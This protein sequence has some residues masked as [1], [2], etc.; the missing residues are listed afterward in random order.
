MGMWGRDSE[1]SEVLTRARNGRLVTVTGPGG[2]GKTALADAAAASLAPAFPMG[3]VKVDLTRVDHAAGV[4]EAIAA[5]LGYADYASLI[6]SPGDRPALVLVD[7]CEHVLEAAAAAVGQLLEACQMPT[8]LATSRSPLDLPGESIVALGP[9]PVPAAGVPDLRAPALRLLLERVHDQGVT[10]RDADLPVLVEVCRRLD[11]VPLALELAAARLRTVA[12]ADLLREL[13]EGLHRLSRRRFRGRASH[14]GV[15]EL[16]AWS[17]D[18]LSPAA[19]RFFVRLGIFAGPFPAAM[20]CAVAGDGDEAGGRELL[21]DL[22]TASLIVVD[23]RADATWYRLLHPVRAVALALL[24]EVGELPATRSRF[25]NRVVGAAVEVVTD[26]TDSWESGTLGQLLELY[27]NLAASLR[28]T[29]EHDDEPDRSLV[30]LSVLWG[31]VHQAH[32]SEVRALGEQ[33]LARWDDPALPWWPDAAPTVAT[34]RYLRGDSTEAIALVTRA[35]PH[36]ASSPFAPATLRRVLARVHQATGDQVRALDHLAA[37]AAAA[38]A[39]GAHGLAMELRVDHGQVLAALGDVGGGLAEIDEVYAEAIRA[40]APINRV[41]ALAAR[42]AVLA[43][44][45]PS[46][47]LPVIESALSEATSA[48]YPAGRA[49]CLRAAAVARIALGDL[50]AAAADIRALVDELLQTGGLGDL[51]MALDVATVLLHRRGDRRWVDLGATAAALPITSVAVPVGGELLDD[52]RRRGTVLTVRDAYVT[53]RE[54]LAPLAEKAAR[55][56][57]AADSP[58]PPDTP[59]FVLEGEVWCLS[60]AGRTVRLT[61]SKGLADLALLIASP[62]REVSCLELA[63]SAMTAGTEDELVDATARRQYERRVRDLQAEIDEAEAHHDI[64]RAEHLRVEM[65]LLV[66]HLAAALGLGGR[67]RRTAGEAE[68]ARSAVTQRI[69]STLRRIERQHPELGKHLRATV[70]TGMLCCYRP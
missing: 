51:R 49:F 17:F 43:G 61:A 22:V 7:N 44:H 34:C 13:D 62:D 12:P 45:D 26:A 36:A 63:G 9:L 64:D 24:E 46:A 35:M 56:V 70:S 25:I 10:V 60:Y 52:A 20:A 50:R 11:G 58:E 29:V 48:G 30:L 23:P 54:A 69:R 40:D 3:G 32:T 37:A 42:G 47:A 6:N 8:V 2:I 41:W 4:E 66:D 31:V 18:L 21:E 65:D 14:R 59:S 27:D 5:Q 38:D 16:V 28:W 1:L 33:V 67:S 55:S 53:C 15:A 39:A 68:R 19:Q 57:V